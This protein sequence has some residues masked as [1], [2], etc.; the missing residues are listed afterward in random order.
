[1]INSRFL[2]WLLSFLAEFIQMS[3]LLW[4][5]LWWIDNRWMWWVG[6]S[7][8]TTFIVVV[9]WFSETVYLHM[10]SVI[11]GCDWFVRPIVNEISQS[12]FFSLYDS[13]STRFSNGLHFLKRVIIRSSKECHLFYSLTFMLS[14]YSET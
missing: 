11:I 13:I 9:W 2:V 1:M 14:T 3:L 4:G 10:E 6:L 12:S 8:L 5:S 7:Q